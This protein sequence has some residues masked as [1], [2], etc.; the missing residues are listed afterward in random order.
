MI[1]VYRV[2][3]AL[4]MSYNAPF[5]HTITNR[6]TDGVA[7]VANGVSAPLSMCKPYYAL[8][9]SQYQPTICRQRIF[10]NGNDNNA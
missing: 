7:D 5:I 1:T 8:S 4:V 9:P 3:D 6:Q 10:I 2:S